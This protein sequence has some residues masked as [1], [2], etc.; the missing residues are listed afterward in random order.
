MKKRVHAIVEKFNLVPDTVGE[1]VLRGSE[2]ADFSIALAAEQSPPHHDRKNVRLAE[3]N[4]TL[5][6]DALVFEKCVAELDLLWAQ[7]RAEHVE[8]ERWNILAINV[9]Q[10]VELRFLLLCH[11]HE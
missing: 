6:R 5:E 7:L 11:C 10:R 1:V 3:A 4:A 9:E 8:R 2:Q